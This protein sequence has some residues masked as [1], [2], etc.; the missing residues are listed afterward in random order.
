MRMLVVGALG[1]VGRALVTS[2]NN[3]GLQVLAVDREQLDITQRAVVQDYVEAQ[4]PDVVVNAAAYTEVDKAE[5]ETQQAFAVNAHG[6]DNLASACQ[7][8][9]IP[10]VQLSTDYIFDGALGR[11]YREDDAAAPLSVY[12]KSKWQGE[13]AVRQTTDQHIIL[14]VSGVFGIHGNNFVK[15]ILRLANE[16]EQLRVVADQEI[17]P[18]LAQ[19]IADVI[20]SIIR[21][22]AKADSVPWG[23]YHYCGA[24]ASTWHA[25]AS[26]IVEVAG[27]QQDLAAKTV[28]AI[29]TEQ[30]P[31]A[32]RRPAN[33][34]LD[35]SRLEQALN[36]QRPSW[37]ESLPAVIHELLK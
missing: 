37:T 2:A 36:I 1:Q 6:P 5:T 31:T 9:R 8:R 21:R 23:T 25:F 26:A 29:T 33:S 35:C 30:F 28:I 24:P 4:T 32:A 7:H 13:Q 20:A 17:C 27:R 10:L 19:D 18:T 11:P 14:R 16:H 22:M 34:V 3:L 15:T 12:G